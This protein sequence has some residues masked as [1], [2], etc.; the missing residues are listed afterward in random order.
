MA[1]QTIISD[2]FRSGE[3][4][5]EESSCLL[6]GFVLAYYNRLNDFK[7]NYVDCVS[8]RH[9]GELQ[10]TPCLLHSK[11]HP[12]PNAVNI[13]R[14]AMCLK[15]SFSETP[16]SFQARTPRTLKDTPST[17]DPS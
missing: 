12:N 5:K 9:D 15:P 17:A 13:K 8:Q 2:R 6:F 3:R 4:E 16:N 14:L 11:P 10:A 7:Y 1:A